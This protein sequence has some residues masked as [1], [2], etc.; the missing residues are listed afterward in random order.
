MPAANVVFIGGMYAEVTF[1]IRTPVFEGSISVLFGKF[2]N[3]QELAE[4]MNR[5]SHL[6][7]D[8]YSKEA[9]IA[10][11][12]QEEPAPLTEGEVAQTKMLTLT[13]VISPERDPAATLKH[14]AGFLKTAIAATITA[15]F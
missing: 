7:R 8:K 10:I 15:S 9:E 1:V 14:L 3:R 13:S 4:W 5:F 2:K 12:L 6:L 11:M